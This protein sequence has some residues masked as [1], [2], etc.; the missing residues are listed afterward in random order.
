M[1]L[2]YA[3]KIKE[4]IVV[5]ILNYKVLPPVIAHTHIL[6]M[7]L[8]MFQNNLKEAILYFCHRVT[9]VD[10]CLFMCLCSC[11]VTTENI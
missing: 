11:I 7:I 2:Y 5:D 6:N 3:Q 10:G 1:L 8:K 9:V 4:R